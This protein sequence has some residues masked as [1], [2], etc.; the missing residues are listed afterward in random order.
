ML[1][2]K[3]TK[4][5]YW[6]NYIL[7]SLDDEDDTLLP[8]EEESQLSNSTRSK[9]HPSQPILDATLPSIQED[10]Q[11]ALKERNYASLAENVSSNKA[12]NVDEKVSFCD[13]YL[14]IHISE[15]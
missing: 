12:N 13:I 15:I 3:N 8:D 1:I 6:R 5:F 4:L 14:K 10:I 2:A 9:T 11:S 7:D